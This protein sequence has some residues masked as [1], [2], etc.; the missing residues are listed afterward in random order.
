MPHHILITG[1]AGFI[2]S[3]LVDAC[4]ARGDK[5]R[6]L[7]NFATG[8]RKNLNA[9]LSNIE[10]IEGDIRDLATCHQACKGVDYV[11]HQAALGSVPRSIDDPLTTHDVNSTGLLNML[12]AARDAKV[13]CFIYAASSSTYGDHASL[14]KQ[15]D[16][17]GNPLSPYAV[18]KASNEQYAR[19]FT[20]TYGLPTIGLRYFNI[21]GPRQ[22]PNS[23]YAAVIPKFIKALHTNSA[24]IIFGDGEQSRDFTYIDNAVKANLLAMDAENAAFGEVF[25]VACGQQTTLNHL[26]ARLQT[27]L[28]VTLPAEYGPPRP[29]DVKHSLADISKAQQLLRY[30]D[31]IDI[32]TGLAQLI[33]SQTPHG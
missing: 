23:Q 29:G 18:T 15:E 21:F 13:K 28:K 22:C 26:Y 1:G 20:Q 12:I 16:I 3:H 25:N 17:I 24:P 30:N 6:V 11:L 4:L 14:P 8:K 32:D 2:G 33:A 5:V 7:D 31:L 19:V 9:Q 10:L 27:L